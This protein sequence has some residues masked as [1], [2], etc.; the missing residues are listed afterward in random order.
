M[1]ALFNQ[2]IFIHV[3]RTRLNTATPDLDRKKG[4]KVKIRNPVPQESSPTHVAPPFI[5]GDVTPVE[6]ESVAVVETAS[7]SVSSTAVSSRQAEAVDTNKTV[8]KRASV[9]AG[10]INNLLTV[11]AENL[12][13]FLELDV[14]KSW[15]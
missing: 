7:S 12:Q 6:V 10:S 4:E 9:Q 2:L 1:Q 3:L 15:Y 5:Q 13:E 11:D 14:R 8:A